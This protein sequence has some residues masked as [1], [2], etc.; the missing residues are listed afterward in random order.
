MILETQRYTR[1]IRTDIWG[2][3]YEHRGLEV[4]PVWRLGKHIVAFVSS[5]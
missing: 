2:V 1:S 4:D 5:F 3:E